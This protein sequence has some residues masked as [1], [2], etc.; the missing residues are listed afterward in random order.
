MGMIFSGI[1]QAFAGRAAS[2]AD[3]YQAQVARNN[4]QI[5]EQNARY[6]EQ[7]GQAKEGIIREKTAQIIGEERAAMGANNVDAGSGSAVRVQ[8]DSARMGELDALTVRN[9]AARDAYN[10]RLQSSTFSQEAILQD[11]QAI[12]DKRSGELN[13]WA[14]SLGGAP[15]TASNLANMQKAPPTTN[16]TSATSS[17]GYSSKWDSYDS[18]ESGGSSYSGNNMIASGSSSNSYLDFEEAA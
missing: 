10:W 5:A 2:Q 8:A 7:Q 11:R 12:M 14:T 16:S 6:A 18:G 9:S 4:A 17:T 3:T 13:F 1:G 15:S